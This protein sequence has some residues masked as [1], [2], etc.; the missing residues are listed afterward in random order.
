MYRN[1]AWA[2]ELEGD[3]VLSWHDSHAE[4]EN[5]GTAFARERRTVHV[6]HGE[7][8]RVVRWTLHTLQVVA[9]G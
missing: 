1:G 5:A 2:N 6:I 9:E 8:G 4:A 3:R 7:D